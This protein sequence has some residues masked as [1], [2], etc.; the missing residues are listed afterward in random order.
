MRKNNDNIETFKEWLA[1]FPVGNPSVKVNGSAFSSA[2][3]TID[4][5]TPLEPLNLTSEKNADARAELQ[6][7][8]K[9]LTTALTGRRSVRVNSDHSNGV[10][11]TSI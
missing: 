3:V 4:F 2:V 11:W 9:E 6:S 5:G 8:M 10:Y 1:T 7:R